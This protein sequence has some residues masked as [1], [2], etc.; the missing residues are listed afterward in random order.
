MKTTF[1]RRC[2]LHRLPTRRRP[3]DL[4]PRSGAPGAPNTQT[5]ASQDAYATRGWRDRAVRDAH[6]RLPRADSA[7]RLEAPSAGEGAAES[8]AH[9]RFPLAG[10]TEDAASVGPGAR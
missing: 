7:G 4:Q 6:E 2:E 8:G 1:D 9:E 5:L 10:W 3:V